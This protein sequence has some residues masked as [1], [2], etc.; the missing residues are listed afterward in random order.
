[1][2][3]RNP[4]IKTFALTIRP[5]GGITDEQIE[6]VRKYVVRKCDYY[7][8]ITEKEDDQR[9]LHAGLFLKK[10]AS[11]SN[12][13][14]E[15]LRLFKDLT[16]AEKSVLRDGIK[17]MYNADFVNNYLTKGDNTVVIAR[18]L[19]EVK[20][21]E[22]YFAAVPPK[23]KKGPASVDPF[24]ANL[25]KLW[26]EHKRPVEECTPQNLRNFLMK[27]MNEV[28]VIRVIADNKKI[29]TISCALAR[30]IN[31]ETSFNVEPDPFHQDV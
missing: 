4:P 21:M 29:F 27:M 9:H 18:S 16:P 1:M 20:T 13:C 23:K 19:P 8:L 28:R 22:N 31:R 30:Y 15:V 3:N 11:R 2:E 24:Y 10:S 6:L 25:E 14:N 17:V 5:Y 7:S 12:V 26:Y